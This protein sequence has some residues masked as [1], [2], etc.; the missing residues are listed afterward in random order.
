M[1][2][3]LLTAVISHNHRVGLSCYN[4]TCMQKISLIADEN[5]E[6]CVF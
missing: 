5:A 1:Q 2:K 3:L 6:K 4:Y